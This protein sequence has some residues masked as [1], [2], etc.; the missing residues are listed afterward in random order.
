M[1]PEQQRTE[2]EKWFE[3]NHRDTY[4]KNADW[5]VWHARQPEI[6]QLTVDLKRLRKFVEQVA[7]HQN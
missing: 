4:Q 1:T 5:F 3:D 2:F 7:I 6:D